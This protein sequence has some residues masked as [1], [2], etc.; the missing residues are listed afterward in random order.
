VVIKDLSASGARVEFFQR[1]QLP[2]FVMLIEP[3]LKLRKAARVIWER[4]AAAGL[5]FED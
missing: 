5:K 1:L 4:G 3:T 2:A